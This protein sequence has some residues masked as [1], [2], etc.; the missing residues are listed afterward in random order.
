MS[1]VYFRVAEERETTK[2]WEVVSRSSGDVLGI[3]KWY[4]PWRRYSFLPS[5]KTL[6]DEIC[7]TDIIEKLKGETERFW[8]QKKLGRN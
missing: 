8:K 4:G 3:V 5:D 7:L 1:Y 6:F 2:V